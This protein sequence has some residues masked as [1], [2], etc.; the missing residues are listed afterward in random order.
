MIRHLMPTF[1]REHFTISC[2]TDTFWPVPR[3]CRGSI[4]AH[5]PFVLQKHKFSLLQLKFLLPIRFIWGLFRPQTGKSCLIAYKLT[6]DMVFETNSDLD[7]LKVVVG[8][9]VC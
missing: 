6:H 4:P 9:V 8:V 3:K 5:L 2:A 1:S 7:L